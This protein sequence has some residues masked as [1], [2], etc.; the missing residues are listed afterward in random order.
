[1]AD[2]PVQD[3]IDGG[4][5]SFQFASPAPGDTFE[6]DGAVIFRAIGPS[7]GY[8]VRFSNGRQCNFGDH[9]PYDIVV[10]PGRRQVETGRFA[11]IRFNVNGLV[12]VNYLDVNGDP[13]AVGVQVQVLRHHL[14]LKDQGT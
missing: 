9:K 2:I 7:A 11:A 12:T 6:N 8:T 13:S 14:Q 10:L 3:T 4:T 5:P 1:M